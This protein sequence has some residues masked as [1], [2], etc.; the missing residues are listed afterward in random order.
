MNNML[1]A[2][3]SA[4]YALGEMISFDVGDRRR[5]RKAL[6]VIA[7]PRRGIGR[8]FEAVWGYLGKAVAKGE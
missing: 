5:G 6:P 8:H 4:F 2:V 1:R 7:P 3:R